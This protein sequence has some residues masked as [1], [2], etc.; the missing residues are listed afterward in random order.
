MNHQIT[1]PLWPH[2][3]RKDDV[4]GFERGASGTATI[5]VAKHAED[6]LE[7][8]ACYDNRL[9]TSDAATGLKIEDFFR[10]AVGNR[11]RAT[12]E[13]LRVSPS[14]FD[15]SSSD[16]LCGRG[17]NE[18]NRE[19]DKQQSNPDDFRHVNSPCHRSICLWNKGARPF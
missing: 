5:K 10:Y 7:S 12:E 9:R 2:S 6:Q 1:S 19:D 16:S 4:H 8:P 17:G 14:R 13:G 18:T 3:R 11:E 15:S